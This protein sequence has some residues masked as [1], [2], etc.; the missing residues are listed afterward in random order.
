M[1][2]STRDW[3]KRKRLHYNFALVVAG[4]LAFG[5]MLFIGETRCGTNPD[6]EVTAFTVSFQ[7]FGYLIAMGLANICYL[8][9][10]L[11]E[12]WIKPFETNRYRW[13][14]FLAGTLGSVCLPFLV[15]IGLFISC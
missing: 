5:G 2:I 9:G 8:L 10:P 7:A 4:I 14:A 12:Q 6:Y 3:W 11:T 15:P 1:D 13:T